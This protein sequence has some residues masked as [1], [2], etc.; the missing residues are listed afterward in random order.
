[1]PLAASDTADLAGMGVPGLDHVLSGG[2]PRHR[3]YLLHGD[4]G[5]GKTTLGLQF[6][7]EGV[8]R[9]ESSLYISLSESRVEVEQVARSHGWALEKLHLLEM[10]SVDR[11]AEPDTENTV[12]LPSE[13]ELKETLKPLFDTVTKLSPRRVVVD[14]LSE[15]RLL[16]QS[17][18]HYRRQLMLLKQ[19]F[20]GRDTTV[21]LLD[22]RTGGDLQ[23][24]S[25]A[26]GVI[27]LEQM[28][29]SYGAERR[30]VRVAKLRGV[31]FRGG[32]HD[33]KIETGGL[34]VYPRLVAAEHEVEAE[35]PT[36]TSGVPGL[37]ALLGGGLDPGTSTLISGASG[38][39]KST[40][41]AHYASAAA[42]AGVTGSL[43]LFDEGRH[44]LLKRSR[45]L[46]IGLESHLASNRIK[47]RQV[48]PAE[49]APD[50]LAQG[51]RDDVE[52]EGR[53]FIVIDSLNGY[54]HAMP[55]ER[56]LTLQLHE[57]LQYLAHKRVVTVL[58]MAQQG[59][60][61]SEPENPIDISY[62]ADT[63]VLLRFF[64]G[65]GS[66]RKSIS[67]IKKRSGPHE[68]SIRELRIENDGVKVGEP[69]KDFR[70]VLTGV[71]QF[72]GDTHKL[73]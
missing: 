9:G 2:L 27:A 28:P 36:V 11:G 37:D 5:A 60:L 18:L 23:V 30:R 56:F 46:G 64:E 4:P 71:P 22:D 65:L 47:L 24:L 53:G 55:D 52:K 59:A 29:Q 42:K 58:V 62:I 17:A 50:E 51:I 16:S 20:M 21:L 41:M 19:F 15:I 57:L 25:L 66:V 1:M 68:S 48:D 32:F 54:L 45:A 6:L 13:V 67:I 70:G 14:S 39:G 8:R 38:T 33:Y 34:V 63:I 73:G 43:Y 72:V 7:L 61:T 10:G 49:L 26:H 69:L 40:L 3:V 31:S 12:F 35:R 44:T